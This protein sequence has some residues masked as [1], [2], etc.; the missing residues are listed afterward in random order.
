MKTTLKILTI[1]SLLF[2]IT[3]THSH[4]WRLNA[5]SCHNDN[6]N[7]GY[8]CHPGGDYSKV[9]SPEEVQKEA[10]FREVTLKEYEKI[11]NNITSK[12]E[13][14]YAVKPEKI[15]DVLMKVVTIKSGLEEWSKMFVVF[16]YLEEFIRELWE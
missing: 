9:V 15:D 11:L 10:D 16:E 12:L 2:S 8:H 6:V 1:L 14:V 4:W 3:I 7:W 5:S 13:M